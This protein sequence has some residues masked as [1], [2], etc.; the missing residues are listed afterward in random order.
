MSLMRPRFAALLVV[1]VLLGADVASAR[2]DAER[3]RWVDWHRLRALRLDAEG[4]VVEAAEEWRAVAV[5]LPDDLHAAAK[6]AV[7]LVEVICSRETPPRREDP[8]Y[9]AAEDLIRESVRRGGT[10]DPA[11]AYA[12]GRLRYVDGDFEN[13][14]K[15]LG[16]AR[17]RGFDPARARLWHYRATI[18][19]AKRLIEEK[20]PDTAVR[21]LE[22]VLKDYPDHPD[23]LAALIDLALAWRM[24]G[25]HV[26]AEK[27]LLEAIQ[28][29]PWAA[30]VHLTLGQVYSDQGRW[31][32]AESALRSAL[33]RA[34]E[35]D[36][37]VYTG[38][39]VY[40]DALFVITGMERKRGNL[41]AAERYARTLLDLR[42]DDP[43]IIASLGAVL[44]E[45]AQLM[46]AEEPAR[47]AVLEE[48]TLL[49]RRACRMERGRAEFANRL[50]EVLTL[51]GETEEAT[52]VLAEQAAFEADLARDEK[53]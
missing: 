21:Q 4:R 46:G 3:D 40:Q 41:E 14:E 12:I 45:R 50:A 27:S 36:D 28:D 13:A 7:S 31:D 19:D 23:R 20:Y 49:L 25:E 33:E 15:M 34:Q 18:A 5:L 8:A 26:L 9:R 42:K 48:A 24:R 43:E 44:K 29:S 37:Q 1:V 22:A 38:P 30:R 32:E 11:L 10:H 51:L 39:Q 2:A 47:R 53:R 16:I 35:S 6:A 17:R 52:R